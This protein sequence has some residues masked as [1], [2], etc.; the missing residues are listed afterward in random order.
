MV[1]GGNRLVFVWIDAITAPVILHA[2]FDARF[3]MD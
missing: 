1:P 2:A 3:S